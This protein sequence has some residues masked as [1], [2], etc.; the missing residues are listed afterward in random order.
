ME[1]DTY[2]KLISR[3]NKSTSKIIYIINL[4]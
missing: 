3:L 2:P 1:N 4:G